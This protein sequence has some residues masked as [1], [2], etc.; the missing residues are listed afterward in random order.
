MTQRIE[1]FFLI[2]LKRIEL[3]FSDKTRRIELFVET[4]STNWTLFFTDSK[5]WIFSMWYKEFFFHKHDSRHLTLLKNMT[6]FEKLW[7]TE[8]N[9]SY[10]YDS[11]NGTLLFNLTQRIE[12]F[13]KYYS[14]NWTLFNIWLEELNIFFQ[15]NFFI[16]TQRMK[17][18]N[19]FW[20]V[21]PFFD[22]TWR[23]DFFGENES[24]IWSLF[25][26]DSKKLN[27][28]HLIQ[29]IEP[30]FEKRLTE[31][32][33][34]KLLSEL[35]FFLIW[36]NTQRIERI[37]PFLDITHKIELLFVEN[38]TQRIEPFFLW[39]FCTWLKNT[40]LQYSLEEDLKRWQEIRKGIKLSDA[41]E[42]CLTNL[43]FADDVLLFS[44]SLDKLRDMLCEFKTSTEA[45]GLGIHP[46]KTK[47]LSNQDKTKVKEVTIDNK[48]IEVLEKKRP[49]RDTLDKRSRSRI[50]KQRKS[51]T[52]WKPR[53][54]HFT[55]IA[56]S[57]HRKTTASATDFA[58]STW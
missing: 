24:N 21:E 37:E 10:E 58:F 42:D 55:H 26:H 27:F 34:L 44:T 7:L 57:W 3:L 31:L 38:M 6:L 18:F 48:K 49:A 52:D 50:R 9:P 40:V 43:R 19:M 4:D 35:S 2:W 23:I 32:N 20:R 56:S 16:M 36:K 17:I 29:I 45:V 1:L 30:Y 14:K 22:M 25:E 41:M 12:P 11:Q 51:K 54:Q 8:L 5:I 33:F 28:F 53:G 15:K 47:I 13:S 39:T 46:D